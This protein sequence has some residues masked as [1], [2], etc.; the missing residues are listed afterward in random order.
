[1]LQVEKMLESKLSGTG[2]F[3]RKHNAGNFRIFKTINMSSKYEF[4]P[5]ARCEIEGMYFKRSIKYKT[6]KKKFI[7]KLLE[8]GIAKHKMV[9]QNMA[10]RLGE[11]NSE[12]NVEKKHFHLVAETV[13][14]MGELWT[15]F[16]NCKISETRKQEDLIALMRDKVY[17]TANKMFM[18]LV[19]EKNEMDAYYL[20]PYIA[21]ERQKRA[22]KGIYHSTNTLSKAAESDILSFFLKKN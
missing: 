1:M 5:E 11:I 12:E 2:I 10:N 4:I 14:D 21:Q 6:D 7:Q 9:A 20:Y 16:S 22:N 18:N 13:L 3:V 8:R 17:E 15:K 19:A